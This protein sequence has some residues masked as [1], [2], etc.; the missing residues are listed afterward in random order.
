MENCFLLEEVDNVDV[1][2]VFLNMIMV[3]WI[4]GE[5]QGT[6]S[7]C[8]ESYPILSTLLHFRRR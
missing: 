8:D 3:V 2:S 4:A 7:V 5:V 6:I 1:C